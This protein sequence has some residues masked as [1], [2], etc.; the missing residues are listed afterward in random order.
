MYAITL[1]ECPR[2]A[3][4]GLPRFVPTEAKVAHLR[5]I[6]AAGIEEIDFGSFVS[7]R[8]VPQMAD[9]EDVLAQLRDEVPR[10]PRLIAIIANEKGLDRATEAFAPIIAGRVV[11]ASAHGQPCV[12]YP[13]SISETF[14]K[15]NT[16]KSI[17]ESWPL[18]E[19]LQRRASAGGIELIVYISMG[20]GNPYREPWSPQ[21]VTDTA[22]RLAEIGVRTIS[23]ADTVGLA[24][25]PQVSETFAATFAQLKSAIRPGAPGQT[26]I[27]LG[28][29][30]HA[31][32]DCF[33]DN[34]RAAFEA[35]CRRFDTSLGGYGGCPFAQD[36]LVG[37]IPTEAVVS[38]FESH[39]ASTPVTPQSIAP[40]LASA[41][42][43]FQQYGH[44]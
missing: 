7:P 25:P 33:A 34:V 40:A 2:D 22:L 32:P 37:N 36:E 44:E 9:S 26:A 41:R 3:F 14:Q 24:T 6:V 16:G 21:L 43:I 38:L 1:I 10:L 5:N 23:L 12:G 13:L 19:T 39:G 4:Q 28:A 11:D 31:R 29:H 18:V 17:A 15:H 8:A 35:G 30:F 20:F 27:A 42:Q